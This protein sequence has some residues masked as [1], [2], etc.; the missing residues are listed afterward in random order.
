MNATPVTRATRTRLPTPSTPVTRSA[1]PAR[2]SVRTLAADSQH[3]APGKASIASPAVAPLHDWIHH[4][5]ALTPTRIALRFQDQELAYAQL[6]A[7]VD[8][9]A[10]ALAAT[11]ISRGACV[12]LLGLNSPETIALLFACARLEAMFMPLNWRLAGPEHRQMLADCRPAVLFVDPR[13]IAQTE[14]VLAALDQ[15]A[16]GAT[17][18][19]A[20][21]ESNCTITPVSLGAAPADWIDCTTFLA[22]GLSISAPRPEAV[23]PHC[24]LLL[25]Y[26]SGS[27]G[28]PRGVLL[29]Q[30]AIACNAMHSI[31]MHDLVATDRVLTTLPLFH[32]GG[33]NNQTTPALL[34]GATVVLHPKFDVD[35]TFDSI[36]RDRI[37]L[38]VLVPAQLDAMIASPRWRT[39]N[40]DSLRMITTGS[41]IVPERLIDAVHQRGIALAQ[42]Y[43]ATETCPIAAFRT[44]ADAMHKPGSAGRAAAHCE[45]RIIDEAGRE[46]GV[47]ETGEILIRGPNVMSGY[48]QAPQASAAA[49]VD[50]WF[51]TGDMGRLDHDGFLTV[52]G[53]RKEMIISGGENIHPAEIENLLCESPAIAE[54]TVLGWPDDHWGEIAI[55]VIALHAGHAL[56]ATD[57]LALLDG[58]IA[59]FKHPKRVLFVDA[60]PRT[61]LGKVRREEVRRLVAGNT[62]AG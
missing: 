52:V 36:E 5:A 25:C 12:G 47:D 61:A 57:V 8:R 27:T 56:G 22:R 62:A 50:G 42:I 7:M 55:A 23:D 40:L 3:V 38:T 14:A 17:P 51:H 13:F 29:S 2:S 54:A 48:W 30:D 41:M 20:S 10:S 21:R 16:T 28:K 15:G 19:A 53:R 18:G 35:A 46:L 60:L 34:V 59:R 58:R 11:G 4:H 26:T 44:A 43:G 6:A 1:R 49:L 37:T 24:S 33:L 9:F 45:L 31:A 39:A 32:V